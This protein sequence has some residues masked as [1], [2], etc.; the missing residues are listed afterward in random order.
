[1][2]S[3]YEDDI[4]AKVN[5]LGMIAQLFRSTGNVEALL[6]QKGLLPLLARTLREEGK[7]SMDL[8]INAVTTFFSV[9][10]FS[11][12]HS[13]IMDN[14][15]GAMTMDL[16]TL[17]IQRTAVRTQ[18]HGISPAEVAQKVRPDCARIQSAPANV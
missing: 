12:L 11:S 18:E 13:Y 10:N 3:L 16:V 7:K 9:S 2:E 1:M 14:Q 6:Q 5:G 15:V 4:S 17:E 8:A